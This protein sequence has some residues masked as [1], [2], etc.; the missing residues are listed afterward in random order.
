ML[1]R[2]VASKLQPGYAQ[3]AI[4]E[5][6]PGAL[7][8]LAVTYAKQQPPD[9]N[10]ILSVSSVL[11]TLFPFIYKSLPYDASSD[12]VTL[13]TG[14]EVEYGYAVG[15]MVPASVRTIDGYLEWAKR[16]GRNRTFSTAGVLPTMV[17]TLLGKI[18][19]MELEPVTYKGGAPAVLDAVAGNVPAT[20]TTLGDLAP[21]LGDGKLRVLAITSDKRNPLMREVPTFSEQGIADMVIK[22]YF[23]F[24]VH[25]KTP[26]SVKESH[27]SAIRKV[28][29]ERDIADSLAQV[30]MTVVPADLTRSAALMAQDRERW[31]AIVK[32]INYQPT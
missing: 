23:G 6:K 8:Q 1:S 22:T 4:V 29:A 19:G 21:H 10:T 17:G 12:F 27:S 3:S 20:V 25:A 9:G 28:L 31:A 13:T 30:G 32:R 5:N 16:D 24:F 15:P 14:C 18:A 26:N 7:A 2:K 11:F